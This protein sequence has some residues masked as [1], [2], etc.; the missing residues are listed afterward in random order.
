MGG[1]APGGWRGAMSGALSALGRG[2]GRIAAFVR[3][4]DKDA[5]A[6]AEADARR[7]E[8]RLREAID[9]LPE[10]IVFLDAEGRYILWNQRY[11][12]IY[13]RSADLFAPGRKLADTLRIGV[14]RGD[15][16]DALG[17]EDEWMAERMA[18]LRNPGVRHE[19]Q[20]ADGRWIMI[21]ERSTQDGGVI[22]LRVDITDMKVQAHALRHALSR[23]EAANRSKSE[24]LANM[25]HEIRTP[26]N[27][28]LGLASVLEGEPLE[29]RHK[30]LVRTI[31]ASATSLDALLSD[32]LTFSRL[33]SGK[34]ELKSEPFRL[35][36]TVR[37]AAALFQPQ[38]TEKGLQLQ[39]RL[40]PAAEVEVVGDPA[41]LGQ[42]IVNLVSNAVKFTDRGQVLLELDPSGPDRWRIKVSDT[43]IGFDAGDADRLFR[44]FEQADGSIT[45]RFGGTGLGL[46]IC[47]QL[48]QLMGGSISAEGRP[49]AGATFSVELPLPLAANVAEAAG[50]DAPAGGLHIL[51]ADDNPTN[52]KVAQLMLEALG[53]K[54]DCA[55]NG[56]EAVQAVAAGGYDLGLIDLQMPVMDGLTAIREIR[57]REA[58]EGRA[59]LPLVVLSANV[60]SED[61]AA[62]TAAGADGHI[63]KP[64]RTEE[65]VEV[66]SRAGAAAQSAS[67]L[68]RTADGAA[69][70]L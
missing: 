28:V 54:V 34:L 20:L 62:S 16:P 65:L 13:H 38:A 3:R 46:A 47:R 35:A 61:V 51:V 11:A 9:A 8:R 1:S 19:Q 25:S 33:D 48:S 31:I 45:R 53:A 15:Y 43:G 50:S 59:R 26:L 36:E 42:I 10:G 63:G 18:L 40:D 64:I 49:G 39:A 5:L 21:E 41:R 55:E 58:V 56:E 52:R 22:G 32:L 2:A 67:R 14:E 27:G 7:A 4:W 68:P 69:S 44:R 30:E 60:M 6:R 17:R 24:F 70:T 37:Q 66:V 29:P 12:E 23:A 57:R